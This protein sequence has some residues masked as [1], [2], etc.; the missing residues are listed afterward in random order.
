ML[1][2]AALLDWRNLFV[3]VNASIKEVIGSYY[4]GV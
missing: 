1:N 4:N 3:C 2:E